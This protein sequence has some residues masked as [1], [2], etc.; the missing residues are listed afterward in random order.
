MLGVASLE[1]GLKLHQS[2][3]VSPMLILDYAV[4]AKHAIIKMEASYAGKLGTL[5]FPFPVCRGRWEKFGR[6][7]KKRYRDG[8]VGPFDPGIL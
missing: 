2:G 6:P 5:C 7:Y 3:I 1:E 4:K 8:K